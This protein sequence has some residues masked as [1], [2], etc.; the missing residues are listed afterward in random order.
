MKETI[1]RNVACMSQNL[2][3]TKGEAAAI[4]GGVSL[5]FINSLLARNKLPRVTLSYKCVRIPRQA[6]EDYISARTTL[7]KAPKRPVE[8]VR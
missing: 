8:A 3:V 6:V 7:G 5:S 1:A 2:L 4:L